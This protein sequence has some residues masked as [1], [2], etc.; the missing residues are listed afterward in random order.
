MRVLANENFPREAVEALRSDGH[1]VS[2]IRED[3]PGSTD[4]QVIHRALAEDRLLVTFDKDFGELAFRQGIRSPCGIMLFRITTRSPAHV[5][6]VATATLKSRHEW[7]G[8]FTVV[9][10]ARIRMLPL[11]TSE[12]P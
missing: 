2:W 5:A 8:H 3:A 1:D 10:D 6:T 9:E 12:G 4:A 7:A 11:P